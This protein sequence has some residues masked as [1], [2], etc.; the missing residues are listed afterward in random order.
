MNLGAAGK[1]AVSGLAAAR[2]IPGLAANY[3]IAQQ[4]EQ[5]RQGRN[6]QAEI[7]RFASNSRYEAITPKALVWAKTAILDCLGTALAGSREESGRILSQMARE[8]AKEETSVYGQN[9]KSSIAQ[10]AFVNGTQA[11]ATDFDHSFVIGG[12]P[13]APIIPAIFAIGEFLGVSGKQL[14]EAYAAGFEVTTKLVFGAQASNRGG[15]P[16]GAYGATTACS[17]LLGQKNQKSRR[18]SESPARW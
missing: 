12:Q 10:A 18:R 6:L 13:T 7:A 4:A 9:F 5:N 15:G 14:L 17:K 1:Y 16:Y 8:R 3:A 11:H 2:M